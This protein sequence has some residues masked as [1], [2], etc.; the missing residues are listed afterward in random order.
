MT[1]ISDVH[2][3]ASTLTARARAA[4]NAGDNDRARE[5]L[6]AVAMLAEADAIDRRT[7]VVITYTLAAPGARWTERHDHAD[8]TH[9]DVPRDRPR[10]WPRDLLGE[11]ST[12]A[13]LCALLRKAQAE[14]DRLF[15]ENMNLEGRLEAAERD[16]KAGRI[17]TH[18]AEALRE[19]GVTHPSTSLL[20]LEMIAQHLGEAESLAAMLGNRYLEH[21]IGLVRGAARDAVRVAQ[22]ADLGP[23]A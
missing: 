18:A 8:G 6:D 12:P 15:A 16:A 20:R 10:D 1:R 11:S 17:D 2:L 22:P 5:A 9:T 3:T 21:T 23:A 4:L 19:R 7:P 14:R 13:E